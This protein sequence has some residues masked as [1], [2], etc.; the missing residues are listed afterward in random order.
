MHVGFTGVV[1]NDEHGKETREVFAI[2]MVW[3]LP[4]IGNVLR[5]TLEFTGDTF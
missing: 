3:T 2:L 5:L 4:I 1:F